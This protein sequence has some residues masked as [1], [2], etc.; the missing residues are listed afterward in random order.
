MKAC[1]VQWKDTIYKDLGADLSS[2]C[3][4]I[5]RIALSETAEKH[6]NQQERCVVLEKTKVVTRAF[7]MKGK[8]GHTILLSIPIVQQIPYDLCYNQNLFEMRC[9]CYLVVK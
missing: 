9:K 5:S 4:L 1:D 6:T 2:D 8:H 3:W 7:T